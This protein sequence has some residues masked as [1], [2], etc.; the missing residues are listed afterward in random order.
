MSDSGRCD[1]LHFTRKFRYFKRI[2]V[3]DASF[4]DTFQFQILRCGTWKRQLYCISDSE[5]ADQRHNQPWDSY[6]RSSCAHY[7]GFDS[8]GEM[9]LGFISP[10]A[11][12]TLPTANVA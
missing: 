11:P 2:G 5:P 9:E 10:I 8:V 12:S 4:I 1:H 7:S 6:A 3:R